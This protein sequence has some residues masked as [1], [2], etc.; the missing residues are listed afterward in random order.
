MGGGIQVTLSPS[1]QSSSLGRWQ[2]RASPG[3]WK[4]NLGLDRRERVC[5]CV[6]ECYGS[7]EK[8]STSLYFRERNTVNK[9]LLYLLFTH[10]FNF[11][12]W[13]KKEKK[14]KAKKS[15]LKKHN[16]LYITKGLISCGYVCPHFLKANSCFS[17]SVW[18]GGIKTTWERVEYVFRVL[19]TLLINANRGS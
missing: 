13:R 4:A 14:R 10:F 11:F 9:T 12:C 16:L 18:R 3:H 7:L 17:V 2:L 5:V 15:P 19:W 6:F 8:M 1:R